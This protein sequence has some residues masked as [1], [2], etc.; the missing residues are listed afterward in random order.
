[1]PPSNLT[2]EISPDHYLRELYQNSGWKRLTL[3]H[4]MTNAHGG[5]LNT[6]IAEID[7]IDHPGLDGCNR[8]CEIKINIGNSLK[9]HGDQIVSDNT[10]I[11]L[12]EVSDVVSKEILDKVVLNILENNLATLPYSVFICVRHIDRFETQGDFW[13]FE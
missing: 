13:N 4:K 1:M 8:H 10:N 12:K 9:R 7:I 5:S 3:F 2:I 6:P 11:E